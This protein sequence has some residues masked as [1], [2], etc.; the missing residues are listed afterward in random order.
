M[1]LRRP[2]HFF[3]QMARSAALNQ[4]YEGPPSP[5]YLPTTPSE[6][7]EFIPHAWVTSAMRQA[8]EQG[9]LD[10]AQLMEVIVKSGAL[11]SISYEADRGFHVDAQRG[12]EVLAARFSADLTQ[13]FTV[14]DE[15]RTTTEMQPVEEDPPRRPPMPRA[16]F[17]AYI[18]E[19]V[20]TAL[21]QASMCW[22]P[23]PGNQV[24]DSTLAKQVGQSLV[25]DVLKLYDVA[26]GSD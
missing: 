2:H 9:R 10:L 11:L 4:H 17:E 14:F 20:F 3:L 16:E 7:S 13:A 15:G 21:G 26:V 1:P 19:K 24:F 18:A 12:R 23:L 6:A 5:S 8:H 22:D 25:N